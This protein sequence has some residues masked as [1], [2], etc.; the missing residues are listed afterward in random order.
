M[1]NEIGTSHRRPRVIRN[2]SLSP[3]DLL[4]Q[5]YPVLRESG[6]GRLHY[7]RLDKQSR[8]GHHRVCQ[9]HV[10]L[11]DRHLAINVPTEAPKKCVHDLHTGQ[12]FHH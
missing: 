3:T 9:I 4:H 10:C 11:K 6:N 2:L 1:N 8:L 12:L 7:L 5:L